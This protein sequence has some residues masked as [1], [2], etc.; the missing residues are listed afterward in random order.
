MEPSPSTERRELAER[1]ELLSDELAEVDVEA[2]L[3]LV[4][5][6]VVVIAFNAK[7]D[8]RRIRALFKPTD[9]VRAAAERVANVMG[10][11]HDWLNDSVRRLLG[12]GDTSDPSLDVANLKLFGARPDYVLAVKC[13]SLA[14][15]TASGAEDDIRYLLRFLDIR[16]LADAMTLIG[17]YFSE[18]QLPRDIEQ[19]LA[20]ILG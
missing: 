3:C 5:G 10:L 19:R 13:A 2:E 14:F 15:D 1:F 6:A 12:S 16:G 7:P 17:R 11:P 9:L 20:T 18:R 8:T 4:G